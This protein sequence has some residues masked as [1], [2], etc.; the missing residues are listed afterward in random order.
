MNIYRYFY[1]D[2]FVLQNQLSQLDLIANERK[3][4]TTLICR[5]TDYIQSNYT[6]LGIN[7]SN[8]EF[9]HHNHFLLRQMLR[10]RMNYFCKDRTH[11]CISISLVSHLKKLTPFEPEL[12]MMT[13]L[14]SQLKS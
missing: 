6:H 9:E 2:K 3:L 1:T 5:N 12:I 4:E 10:H 14:S 8:F 11:F 7:Y 13:S